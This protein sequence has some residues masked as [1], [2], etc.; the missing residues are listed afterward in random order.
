MD[1][2]LRNAI[3]AGIIIIALSLGYY[4]IIFLPKKEANRIELQKKDQETQLESQKQE[5]E[6]NSLKNQ[7]KAEKEKQEEENT[8][9]YELQQKKEKCNSYAQRIKDKIESEKKKDNEVGIYLY[10]RL[11]EL[12]Y[13]STEDECLYVLYSNMPLPNQKAA[14]RLLLRNAVTDALYEAFDWPEQKSDYENAIRRYRGED[15]LY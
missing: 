7:E 11:D 6:T 3:I 9:A 12:F 10:Q 5:H 2:V 14:Q 13:S 4:L 1:K 8:K 15:D